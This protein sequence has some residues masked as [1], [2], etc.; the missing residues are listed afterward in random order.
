MLQGTFSCCMSEPSCEAVGGPMTAEDY[1]LASVPSHACP[2]L[3]KPR[4]LPSS[5]FNHSAQPRG[6]GTKK[7]LKSTQR[8]EGRE[9][10]GENALETWLIEK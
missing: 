7:K 3:C 6:A 1:S 2:S 5:L 9:R 8:R 4:A 10:G